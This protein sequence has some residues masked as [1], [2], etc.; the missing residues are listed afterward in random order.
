M[1]LRFLFNG[2]WCKM[3]KKELIDSHRVRFDEVFAINDVTFSYLVGYYAKD[4]KVDERK[5]YCVTYR[6]NSISFVEC[7]SRDI[8]QMEVLSRKN[9]FLKDHYVHMFDR[10]ML[11]PIRKGLKSRNREQLTTFFS[12]GRKY[13][14][15][16]G[17][18]LFKI[19]KRSLKCRIGNIWKLW[20]LLFVLTSGLSC[21]QV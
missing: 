12:I 20:I 16:K 19:V 3:V 7:Y 18:I 13:G 11:I 21:R 17:F 6:S 4:V 8:L 9:R 10:D 2:P 15:S 14:F 5:I 1:Q